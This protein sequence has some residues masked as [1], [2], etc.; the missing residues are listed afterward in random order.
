MLRRWLVF[1]IVVAVLIVASVAYID[2][3][4]AQAV[5]SLHILHRVL[6]QLAVPSRVLVAI[7]LIAAAVAGTLILFAKPSR[8][9]NKFASATVTSSIAMAASYTVTEFLLKP[10]FGRSLP[11]AF[12]RTGTYGFH[13]FKAGEAYGSFPSG[14]TVQVVSLVTVLCT[15]YPRFRYLWIMGACI[16]AFSLIIA[17]AHFLSDVLAGGMLGIGAG[18]VA[19]RLRAKQR[20]DRG[21]Q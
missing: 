11:D 17:E 7:E 3:P 13:W 4:L 19:L 8:A 10:F 20:C 14:H 15:I 9:I 21:C 12:L 18:I 5:A 2:R 1:L 6:V 16:A